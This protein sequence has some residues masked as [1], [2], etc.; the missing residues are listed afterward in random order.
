MSADTGEGWLRFYPADPRPWLLGGPESSARWLTLAFLMGQGEGDEQAQAIRR[1]AAASSEVSA[2]IDR[3]TAWDADTAASGHHSPSYL[4]NVLHL[5]ADL[6]VRAGDDSRIEGLLDA[7]CERQDDEGRFL[8]YG[9]APQHPEPYWGT[10]ACDTHIITDLL[11]RFGRLDDTVVRRSLARMSADLAMTTQGMG[12]MCVPEPTSGFRGPGRKDDMCPQVTLEAL[13]VFSRVPVDLRPDGLV[14]AASSLLAVWRARASVRPYMFGHGVRFKVVKWPPFW[15][16]AY[17][18]LDTLGRYP[19]LWRT[20]SA[21][22]RASLAEL[23]ACLVAYNVS[24]DGTVTPQSVYRGFEQFSFG[25]KKRPSPVATALLATVA[26]RFADLGDEV[27]GVDVGRLTG[28]RD[29]K[30]VLP[31]V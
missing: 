27:T 29:G 31:R 25:Q 12:W 13:R 26:S 6:G 22:D 2:L 10:L 4:P 28:S 18:T 19:S 23:V 11:I 15:Y 30:A 8:A 5:L 21:S 24:P 20:G 7:M 17:W 9:K 16:G 14:S 3:L 1:E